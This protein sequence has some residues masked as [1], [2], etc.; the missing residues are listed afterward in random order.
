MYNQQG[1]I[2]M[3]KQLLDVKKLLTELTIEEKAALLAGTDF[4]YTNSIPRLGIPTLT[5]A[6]GPH[7]LRKQ[8]G[9]MDNGISQSEPATA[10][11]TAVTTSSSWN[12]ENSYKMGQAIA[13]E[14]L[15]YDVNILLGPGVNIKRNPRCGRNFEYF[16]EDP[17][18]ASSFG[19]EFVKGVQGKNV[20]V[21]VKHFAA[22]NSENYR[23]VG[24]SV[25]DDRALRE[26]YL[27]AFEPV[28]RETKPYTV[29]SAYN[30]IH[31]TFCSDN[32]WLLTDVLRNEWGFDGAVMSDWGGT[33]ERIEAVRAGLDLEMPGDTSYCRKQIIDKA[34]SGEL[35]MADLD[36]AVENVL[37]LVNSCLLQEH[38]EKFDKIA[39]HNLAIEIACDSAVLL[40]NENN[41]LPLNTNEKLCIVGEL[42][43][44][45][46]Y[47]GSGSSMI[48]PTMVESHIEA[49]NNS[50]IQYI[51][52]AGYRVN[53]ADT[54]NNLLAKALKVTENFSKVVVY[55]GLTDYTESEGCDREHI[56]LPRN[57]IDLIEALVKAG[58][59]VILVLFGGSP[60]ELPF[61]DKVQ[62]ILNMYLPGQGGG[63]ATRRLLFGEVCPSGKL[64]ETWVNKYSDIP[65]GAD[66]SVNL[67]E[68]YKESIYVGYRYFETFNKEVL[69]PFGYGLSYTKFNYSD[70]T[71]DSKTYMA[72]FTV[73]NSGIVDGAEVVQLYVVNNIN[74]VFK[75]KKELK[76]FTKVY[77]KAGESKAVALQ[78]NKADLAYFNTEI[79]NWVVENGSYAVE[80]G[81]S[82]KDIKFSE[83]FKIEGEK[84]VANPY[85]EKLNRA[86]VDFANTEITDEFFTEL[87]RYE[88][89]QL[90]KK[91]PI[92][93]D[94]RFTDLNCTF[95]G[96]ILYKGI[97]SI[98]T[99]QLKNAQKLP[100]GIE[101][102]N[103]IK[104]AIFMR[105]VMDSNSI[106]TSAM[107]SSGAMPMNLA[108]GLV[109]MANGR[110]FSGI[111]KM[112]KKIKVPKLPK[113]EEK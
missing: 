12:I 5:M 83:S 3:K 58:K 54:D 6:D 35:A 30:S 48:N 29:M 61:A 105:R 8:V 75:A 33:H 31:S 2:F 74:G 34:H 62:A 73:T 101:R 18:V 26:I 68:K 96:R 72:Q 108:E 91:K 45:M 28:I 60:V 10:F 32:K 9:A 50:N 43:E 106:R 85:S 67:V 7:G 100:E 39:H 57:Q 79:N 53:T 55:A 44:K 21:S 84:E 41:I 89:P 97:M 77:L 17:L 14:C 103:R 23:F 56:E 102:E 92:H 40:K 107:A 110:I 112:M 86:Y 76:A 109:H 98:P 19:K 47:Q 46:R 15:Y 90:P 42:F 20:G 71:F 51:Y 52:S 59:K 4:M 80:V 95:M 93:L 66:Y 94:S 1:R 113:E 22:N 25:V 16:S 27:K 49:F 104:G 99:K 111:G 64:T 87:L 78:F 11:P 88:I 65:Y 81:A 13:E 37:N 24:H 82:I 69:Y 38:N 63:E 70:F 36:K